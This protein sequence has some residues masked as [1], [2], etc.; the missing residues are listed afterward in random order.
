LQVVENLLIDVAE[1]LAFGQVVKV[2]VIDLVDYLTHQL[3]GF[4]IVVGVLEHVSDDTATVA[5]YRGG[6]K[7]LQ[8]RKQ[9]AV[10]EGEQFF[11]GDAFRVRRPRPPLVGRRDRGPVAVLGDFEFLILIVDDLEKKHPA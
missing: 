5:G 6:H 7:V 2:Y 11:A 1:V 10:D 4:H 9:I 8:R 3:A